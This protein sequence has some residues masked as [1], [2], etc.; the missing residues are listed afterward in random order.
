MS[1]KKTILTGDRPTGP[2][3]L[4]HYAGS[5]KNR[6][7]LQHQYR[8][9]VEIADVQAL[10]DNFHNPGVLKDNIREV[11]IDYLSVG[12]DPEEVTFVLQSRIP[13]IH[14]LA[15]YYLNMV[16]V[17]RAM[18]NPTVKSEIFDKRVQSGKSSMFGEDLE[19]PLG[20][21][22][23]PIHQAADITA[24]DADIVPVGNDQLPMLEQT[25]EIVR[26]INSYY[27]ENTLKLPEAILGDCER[28]P[29]IDGKSK[30]SKSLNNGIYLKDSKETVEKKIRS[31]YT[32]PARI[33]ADIP[34][35]VE[36]NPLFIYHDTFNR[37]KS[38]VE[39]FKRLYR[40]GQIG[41]MPIK[42]RLMEEIN[43]L[44]KPFRERRLYYEQ[45][46]GMV[47]QMLLDHSS[48]ARKTSAAVLKRVKMAMKVVY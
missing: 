35:K 34:G 26:K 4:G 29:G 37:D 40:L 39:E 36:G 46:L 15:I 2:L 7:E 41:D 9:F 19:I 23:Y 18:R 11:M 47:E 44:L 22:V 38:E 30:M 14:E 10:T 16:T 48:D 25:R 20:F 31:L 17:S 32:D 21:L 12:L 6:V 45:K 13:E 27:G 8:T 1:V 24:F 33:R 3:H 43:A 42:I 5:L 28:L